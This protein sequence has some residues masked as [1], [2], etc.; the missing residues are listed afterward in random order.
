MTKALEKSLVVEEI[1]V[2]GYEKV[3]K[4]TE[5]TSG[6]KAIIAIHNTKL[7]PGLGGTRIY[8]YPTFEAA[9]TDVLRL[10]KGMTYKSA[11]AG[12][13]LGGAKSV[14]ISSIKEKT[15]EKLVAF[16]EAVNLLKGSYTCAEDV[17]CSLEDITFISRYTPYVVGVQH[18][19][20]SGNPAPF[21]A[22]GTFR[23]VQAVLQK[24]TGSP[25]VEGKTVA[26][27][28][29]GSVGSILV[30]HLFWHGARLIISDIDREKTL[31]LAKQFHAEA[32]PADDIMGVECDVLAPC[33]LGGTLNATTIP[34]LRCR[35]IAGCAN[36]Q[37]LKEEDGDALKAHGILYAP[38]FVINAGGLINVNEEIV[39][40]GYNA[41]VARKKIHNLYDELLQIFELAEK[42]GSS[43]HAAAVSMGDYRLAN[44]ITKRKEAPCYHHAQC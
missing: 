26:V 9:L 6:L 7:G 3:V 25:S 5:E 22:W 31:R 41:L 34:S 29:L 35:A 44:G 38:D 27:Q 24:L 13:G 28:G 37:L 10:S 40:N 30:E 2:P 39:P 12:A 8:P 32:C 42:N 43:T 15:P 23:G 36:N 19:K 4:I 17:G 11:L 21:T 33:A 20:S 14:I 16:A 18:D 1:A